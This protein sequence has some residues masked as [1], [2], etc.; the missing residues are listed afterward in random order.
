MYTIELH[1]KL[2]HKQTLEQILAVKTNPTLYIYTVAANQRV[3]KCTFEEFCIISS[4]PKSPTKLVAVAE[5][6]GI[7][8]HDES[9]NSIADEFP[10]VATCKMDR[11]KFL[12][13]ASSLIRPYNGEPDDLD[14]FI[15]NIR[16]IADCADGDLKPFFL[17]FVKGRISGSLGNACKDATSIENLISTLKSSVHIESHKEIISKLHA[18][19][20]R[21]LN[22]FLNDA[23]K[24]G[25][26]LVDSLVLEGCT[27][28]FAVSTTIEKIR[29]ICRKSAKNET[30]K[31]IIAAS[32]YNSHREVLT[33]FRLEIA[34]LKQDR[35]YQNR[36]FQRP[37]RNGQTDSPNRRY[38]TPNHNNNYNNNSYNN[39][40]NNSN[41]FRPRSGPPPRQNPNH[42]RVTMED[43][44]NSEAIRWSQET[45]S[46]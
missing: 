25:D 6:L 43:P 26:S 27:R 16:L 45:S 36:P 19:D 22:S 11:L 40:N 23:E 21:Q 34:N 8:S 13:T 33:S 46:E 9:F 35:V 39:Y 12:T 17:D 2:I 3:R 20:S 38:Q 44:E 32:S 18:L 29:E 30:L 14:C 24:L 37:N 7:D 42:I 1:N 28:E 4:T 5:E 41:N 31:T 15:R 10:S